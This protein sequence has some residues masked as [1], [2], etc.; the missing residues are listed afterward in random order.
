MKV[1]NRWAGVLALA[2]SFVGAIGAFGGFFMALSEKEAVLA[3]C[4]AL[5]G[6]MAV[7]FIYG[8]WQKIGGKNGE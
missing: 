3:V 6:A 2:A 8:L 7:P 5:T 4:V 1:N